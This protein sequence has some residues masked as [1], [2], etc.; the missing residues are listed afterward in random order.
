MAHFV[1]LGEDRLVNLD[2]IAGITK[3]QNGKFWVVFAANSGQIT[4]SQDELGHIWNYIHKD[5]KELPSKDPNA[6]YL[7]WMR[8][9][10]GR[11]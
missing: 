6:G 7:E 2:H 8:K 10:L 1:R 3:D 4:V 11:S 5:A 9:Q